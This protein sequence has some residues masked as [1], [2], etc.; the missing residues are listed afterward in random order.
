MNEREPLRIPWFGEWHHLD[1]YTGRLLGVIFT[2]VGVGIALLG[3]MATE[4]ESGQGAIFLVGFGALW[5]LGGVPFAIYSHMQFARSWSSAT[6]E[7][8]R[9]DAL[10]ALEE[11]GESAR[12]RIISATTV[13][14]YGSDLRVRVDVEVMRKGHAPY[15]AC[16]SDVRCDPLHVAA[17][18]PGAEL[19]VRVDVNDPSAVVLPGRMVR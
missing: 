10:S 15:A 3:V 11:S 7:W 2:L 8:D 16:L 4:A 5:I 12:A 13:G 9:N 6:Q 14:E 18:Q 1:G 19:Q 17:L